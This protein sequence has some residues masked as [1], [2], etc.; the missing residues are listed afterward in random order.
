MKVH[1]LSEYFFTHVL[2]CQNGSSKYGH[3]T[4]NYS[5]PKVAAERLA[6]LLRIREVPG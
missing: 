1:M 2:G 3:R 5:V 6:F 4:T